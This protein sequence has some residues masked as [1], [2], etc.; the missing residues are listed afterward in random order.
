M[1]HPWID[2]RYILWW[3]PG[4]CLQR[5]S[6]KIATEYDLFILNGVV[7]TDTEIREYDVAIKGEKIA[8]VVARGS[9]NEV[10]ALKTID[11][12]GG[13]QEAWTVMFISKN[14]YYLGWTRERYFH[15]TEFRPLPP[16]VQ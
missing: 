9:L 5:K 12:E 13:C 10:K 14:L 11:A 15:R 6:W 4:C 2:A 8:K 1:R 16:S 3:A 7:V